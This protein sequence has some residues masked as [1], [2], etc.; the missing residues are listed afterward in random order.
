M[1]QTKLIFF[2][3]FGC[4]SAL[5]PGNRI[6]FAPWITNS[7]LKCTLEIPA[8]RTLRVL[9][10]FLYRYRTGVSDSSCDHRSVVAPFWNYKKSRMTFDFDFR[11]VSPICQSWKVPINRLI[12][13]Y[14]QTQ[15]FRLHTLPYLQELM[16]KP[17]IIHTVVPINSGFCCNA[18]SAIAF[19][20]LYISLRES[21]QWNLG[22]FIGLRSAE[23]N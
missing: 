8:N 16:T 18:C 12:L 9:N 6:Q 17:S 7:M 10:D 1:C 4:G 22:A 21:I 20:L 14:V 3:K 13:Q 15:S 23:Q 2:W 5:H 19:K 11:N